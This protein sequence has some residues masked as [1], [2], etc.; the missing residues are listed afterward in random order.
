METLEVISTGNQASQ[1]HIM[2]CHGFGATNRDLL[3]LSLNLDP[4]GTFG[5]HFPQ[6]P[7]KIPGFAGYAWF[8]RAGADLSDAL[9]G[10][11]FDH[12]AELRE[13]GLQLSAELLLNWIM[14]KKLSDR[15]WI[16]G[17]FSQGSMVAL[18][19]ALQ[20]PFSVQSVL[21]LSGALINKVDTLSMLRTSKPFPIFQSHG[22]QDPVLAFK[23]ASD[24]RDLL[25]ENRFMTQWHEFNGGH[26]IPWSIM[27][28]L[29]TYLASINVS[30]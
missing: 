16:F 21:I 17:G 27:E 30:H 5:W 3:D 6:A 2:L 10:S 23:G 25:I 28:A 18:H 12:L 9:N 7:I 29:S 14:E 26:E 8:P 24:L 15:N 1:I 4:N 20:A 19:T 13:T 22:R 11:Y